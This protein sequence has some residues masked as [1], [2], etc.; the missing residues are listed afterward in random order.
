MKVVSVTMIWNIIGGCRSI[1]NPCSC[2]ILP[3]HPSPSSVPIYFAHRLGSR[4]SIPF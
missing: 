4:C 2:L 1:T 3:T